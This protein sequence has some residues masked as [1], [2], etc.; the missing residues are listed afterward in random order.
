MLSVPFAKAIFSQLVLLRD[1]KTFTVFSPTYVLFHL[2]LMMAASVG[3]GTCLCGSP[4]W[5]DPDILVNDT[6]QSS[7]LWLEG[8]SK[9]R[10]SWAVQGFWGIST[11]AAGMKSLIYPSS[12]CTSTLPCLKSC[13]ASSHLPQLMNFSSAFLQKPRREKEKVVCKQ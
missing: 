12:N 6:I 13:S 7:Y 11:K 8:N 5:V 2:G 3:T 4:I 1:W 10:V 9:D